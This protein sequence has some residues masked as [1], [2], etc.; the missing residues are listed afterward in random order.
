MADFVPFDPSIHEPKDIG[1]GGPSTEYLV[2]I[3]S[4]DGQ[5]MVVPSIWWDKEGNPTFLGNLET[6]DINQ[7]DILKFVDAYEKETKQSFPRFGQAGVKDNYRIADRFASTRSQQGGASSVPLVNALD[8]DFS[9][10]N[11]D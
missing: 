8:K 1:L 11:V 5:V 7:D 9:N 2:T 4:P 3:D 10:I 6:G